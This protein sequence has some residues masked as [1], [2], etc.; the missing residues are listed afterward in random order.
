MNG[1]EDMFFNGSKIFEASFDVFA[2]NYHAVRPGYPKEMYGDI[3][4]IGV[5]TD[6]SRLLEIG[7]GSGIATKELAKYGC[8]II[9]IEPGANLAEIA[10][11]HTAGCNGVEIREEMFETFQPEGKFDTILALTSFH[12]ISEHMKYR[13]VYDLLENNG[14]FVVVWNSFF[15]SDSPVTREINELYSELLPEVYPDTGTDINVSVMSK[16]GSREKEIQNNE[17]FYIYFQRKYLVQYNYDATTY[18][19]LLNTFP[20]I[21]QA[22]EEARDKFLFR[23][24]EI[25]EKYGKISVPVLTTL[26]ICRKRDYFLK[27]VGKS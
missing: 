17:L 18:P 8:T 10:R 27:S 22:K 21:V 2:G 15:Q 11:Q 23:V 9:G 7:A 6:T 13:R 5:I 16:L 20:K 1:D 3:Q 25:V 4:R 24:G 19:Q 26:I 14:N 12:W